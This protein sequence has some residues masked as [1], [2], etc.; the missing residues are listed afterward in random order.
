FSPQALS[1]RQLLLLAS[2]GMF[3][4]LQQRMTTWWIMVWPCLLL[5]L[6]RTLQPRLHWSWLDVHSIPSFRKTAL[7]GLIVIVAAMW[8]TPVRWLM[9]GSKPVPLDR[10]VLGAT[11]WALA[12]ELES[13]RPGSH[14]PELG[15][16][17]NRGYAGRF[18]GN[19]FA[20]ETVADYL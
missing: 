20:S 5:P 7:A 1:A 6:L 12:D 19:I 16:A 13:T 9:G 10:V 11:V 18:T 15:A 4:L 2:F 17:L 8:T 14:Y 3:P